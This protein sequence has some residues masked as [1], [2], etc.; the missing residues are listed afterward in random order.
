VIVFSAGH[1]GLYQ[2]S[3]SGG[4]PVK[5]PVSEKDQA[6]YRWPSFLPDGKHVLVTSNNASGGIFAVSLATGQVQ[7]LLSG[8]NGPAQYLEPGYLLFLRGGILLAQPF[9][10]RS[11]RVTGS[12]QSIAESVSPGSSFSVSGNGLLLYQRA[13]QSQLTW[14]DSEGKKLSTVGDPGYLSAPYLSPDGRYV[15]VTVLPPG[16][17]N[18]KLWLYDL[19]QGTVSPFTFGEG[20]DAYPAWSP[21]SQQVAFSSTRGGQEDI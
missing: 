12:A 20:D 13:S 3:A 21:D 16:Q 4:T 6:D 5:V 1:L 7:L 14:M 2:I 17:K 9:D 11:L 8:E 18:Q 10:A 15:M 19:S